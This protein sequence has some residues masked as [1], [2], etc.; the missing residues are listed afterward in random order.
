MSAVEA[1][2]EVDASLSDEVIRSD[3]V[4]VEHLHV[5]HGILRKRRLDFEA[6]PKHWIQLFRNVVVFIVDFVFSQK[7]DNIWVS[8]S[9]EVSRVKVTALKIEQKNL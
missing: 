8:L 9:V 7:K 5:E 4:P 3:Q 1:V 2:F 6:F